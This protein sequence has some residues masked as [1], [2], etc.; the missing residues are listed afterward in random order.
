MRSGPL[1]A[2]TGPLCV[3]IGVWGVADPPSL[4]AAASALTTTAFRS[5][6]WF[7]MLAISA[8]LVIGIYLAAS[9]FGNVRLGQGE[10]RP[11][12]ST[13]SWLAMLFAA[14]MGTGL[15]FWGVAEPLTHFVGAPGSEPGSAEA[16]RR[17]LL[18]TGFHWGFHAW[19]IYSLAA[20]T[21]GYFRFRK[22]APY[23]PSSPIRYAFRGAWV[24]PVGLAADA[25]AI[26]AVTFGVAGSLAMGILQVKSGLHHLTG[27]SFDSAWSSLAVLGL[28]FVAFMTSAA[29]SLDKGIKWL[30]NINMVLA[31]TLVGFVLLAGPTSYLLRSFIT[32]IGDYATGVVSLSL[33]LHPYAS[34]R[35]WLEGWTLT[36]LIWWIAW[37]PFVGVFIA[38]ISRG[39]TIRE[40]LLGV[41]LVPTGF[42]LF[43]FAV[44]GGLG[45]F[46]E[47]HGVG[48]IADVAAADVTQALFVLFDRLPLTALLSGIAVALVFIFLV[49]SADSATFVLGMLTSDGDMDPPRSKKLIWGVSLALLG[50]ALILSGSIEAVKAAA[51]LGAIPFTFVLLIQVAGFLRV[52]FEDHPR[53]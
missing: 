10:D 12:F 30:S 36:Y 38:R 3:G 1:F 8:L 37:A 21:L 45:L 35:A 15:V 52:L 40:F 44:F 17:A 46:E 19:A 33:Q 2:I 23:L 50:A 43:W 14:G 16:A 41:L 39:R 31:L 49:T 22:G 4:A 29:T 6:D 7:F 47:L 48:G 11:E 34:D 27:A 20:L 13:P 28:L 51:I 24:G 5:L 32:S 9:R 26:I 18:I 53:S 42:S 25:I